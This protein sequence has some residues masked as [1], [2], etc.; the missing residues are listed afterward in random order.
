MRTRSL[1]TLTSLA[2]ALCVSAGFLLA[3]SQILSTEPVPVCDS[4]AFDESVTD[5]SPAQ[6]IAAAR[7]S[8]FAAVDILIDSQDKPLAAYQVTFSASRGDVLIV[9]IEGGEHAAFSDAPFYDPKAI[10]NERAILAGFSTNE[11]KDL[12][13]GRTRVAT[14]HVEIRG[15]IEP[16]YEWKLDAAAT[17][18]GETIP[19]KVAVQ[20]PKGAL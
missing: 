19:A 18:G 13:K 16:Q 12:P 1:I 6:H 3:Q 10:Q 20:T 17:V 9:S 7:L 15:D 4:S 11:A 2:L 8:R 14:V 5:V